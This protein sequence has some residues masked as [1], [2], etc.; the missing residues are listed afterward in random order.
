LQTFLNQAGSGASANDPCVLPP[1]IWTD[2][3]G[4]DALFEAVNAAG[5]Y[6][7]LDMSKTPVGGDSVLPAAFSLD[8]G[9]TDNARA[10]KGR[11]VSF[12]LPAGIISIGGFTN[13][14]A[15]KNVSGAGVES[16]GIAAFNGRSSLEAV[17]FPS[18]ITIENFAFDGCASLKTVNFPSAVTIK[19]FAFRNCASLKAVDFP[20]VVTIKNN[21]FMNCASL[22]AVDFL[23]VVTIEN[24]AFNDCVKL[25]A[26][27]FPLAETICGDA[28]DDCTSLEAVDFPSVKTILGYAFYG[29]TGL[30][31]VDLPN[32]ETIGESAFQYS[33][34][35]GLAFTMGPNAPELANE[36]F[37]GSKTITV[38][39]PA[40]ADGYGDVQEY[41]GANS[42]ACWAN[43]F[44][45]GGWGGS[46]FVDASKI[47]QNITVILQ[48]IQ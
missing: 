11:I 44:R 39:I 22:E 42:T 26:V 29:C 35:A 6:V 47:N 37:N 25:E 20:S 46:G 36:I 30:G 32:V 9:S 33:G 17:N 48:T 40:G 14:T 27:N 41:S 28:F 7:A 24:E 1:V 45:G 2:T 10:G 4:W 13:F 38:N 21:A 31:T 5:K 12:V 43:G 8:S 19:S 18:A 15:I 23:S 34:N 16:I 3:G